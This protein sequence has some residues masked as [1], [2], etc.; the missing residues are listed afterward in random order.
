MRHLV[1]LTLLL[2]TCAFPTFSVGGRAFAQADL[3]ADQIVERMLKQ[4]TFGWDEALTTVRMGLIDASGK[5]SERVMDNLRRRKNGQLQSVVRFRSPQDVAGT[6]FLMLEREKGE[7]EQHIYLPGLKR[8]RRIVGRER[9]GSFMGSDFSYAD[10]ERRDTRASTQKRLPD[11]ELNG[12]KAYVLESTP[13][14]EAG[15]LYSKIETWVRQ[16]NFLPLRIR[17][18]DKGGKLLK[19]F[20]TKRIRQLEGRP[21]IMESQMVNKQSGHTTELIVDDLRP[22]KDLPDSDF[23]PTALEHG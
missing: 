8:T 23:T 15:S 22:Q 5:R 9:E 2:I 20:Y 6:A 11:E 4:D 18:Y 17:F 16:D 19:T 21:V 1:T 7:S 13:K 14:K 12:V 10:M 3:T